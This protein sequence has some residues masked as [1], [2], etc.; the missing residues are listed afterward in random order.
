[1]TRP[2]WDRWA[3]AGRLLATLL[4]LNAGSAVARAEAEHWCSPTAPLSGHPPVTELRGAESYG[5]DRR[6]E[7]FV[8][9]VMQ[10][11]AAWRG[12]Q[13][14]TAAR[15]VVAEMRR[16]AE[17]AALE[18]VA[19]VGPQQSNTNS[20]YSL[21]R[22]LV[23]LL[24]SW[25]ELESAARP[26][27]RRAI[28]AWLARLVAVQDTSTGG[29]GGRGRP[30]AVSNRNNHAY[31]RGTVD[32]LWAAR[33]ADHARAAKAASVVRGAVE[34]MRPDGSLP[35]ETARGARALWYQRHAIASLVAIG[36]ALAPMGHD[37]WAARAD[38]RS[39]HDA[40]TFLIEAV[41][42]PAR[43]AGYAA[44]NRDAKP[45]GEPGEQDLGFLRPRGHGRHYMAWME[46]Y[47]RRFPSNPNAAPLA[48]MVKPN[49]EAARPMID[50]IVG[51]NATCAVLVPRR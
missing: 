6:A 22:A 21:R 8:F 11:A 36:E 2:P 44:A 50:E 15:T 13:D 31:L 9:A 30:G 10:G 1:M 47:L 32:A 26:E 48:T 5:S 41:R 45:G 25:K 23:G 4:L 46:F 29:Q 38:G 3:A 42:E 20:I 17:A 14:S 34:E 33:D 24:S 51:G 28:N 18:S 12:L 7:A 19:D 39:L 49:L 27:D 16:W 35:L 43:V 40:V 37:V